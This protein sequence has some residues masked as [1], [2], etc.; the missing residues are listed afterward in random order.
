MNTLTKILLVALCLFSF[1]WGTAQEIKI[2]KGD[3]E[4]NFSFSYDQGELGGDLK[5]GA[6]VSDYIQIGLEGGYQDTDFLT[7]TDLGIYLLRFFETGT[8]TL[9]YVGVGTGFASLDGSAGESNSGAAFSLILGLRYYLADN[10]AL[11]TEFRSAWASGEAFIDG[12]SASD[13]EFS[14]GIGLSYL[15]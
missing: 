1:S 5:L 8:Y 2:L 3:M 4:T 10:V 14:L 15:W 13:T 6:F 7:Q 12:N 9:P 11:N